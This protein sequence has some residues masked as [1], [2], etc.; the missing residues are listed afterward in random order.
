MQ[1]SE[2]S[3]QD[4]Y[5]ALYTGKS[6][7]HEVGMVDAVLDSRL[8]KVKADKTKVVRKVLEIGCGPGLRLAV[9]QQWHGK[10]EPEGLDRDSAML[11]LA[12]KR[13]PGVPLHLGDMRDFAIKTR[14]S[15]V[16][17]LFGVI[18]YLE[19]VAEMTKALKRMKEHL[20]PG[21][22]LLLE[23]WLTPDLVRS[24]Y[25]QASKAKREGLEVVRMNYTTVVGNKSNIDVNYLIGDE[26]GVRH[27]NAKRVLTLFTD[28]EYRTGLRN[29]GFGDVVLE[30]YGPQG[31]GLYVAQV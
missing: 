2:R 3:V 11:K 26:T 9:L 7:Q 19:N 21:G 8:G 25:L 31:R 18:G 13:V 24:G 4:A 16:L 20:I 27:V 15:A 30:A 23:P 17:C 1:R 14:Y 29:A 6:Y 28:E 22:V 12:A 10:Y 5:E